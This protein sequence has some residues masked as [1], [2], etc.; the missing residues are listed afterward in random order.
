MILIMTGTNSVH[1][2][3]FNQSQIIHY[4]F[5]GLHM[6]QRIIVF[7]TVDTLYRWVHHL[8]VAVHS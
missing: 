7:V 4:D 5:A 8:P 1:V 6:S 2:Q 3:L